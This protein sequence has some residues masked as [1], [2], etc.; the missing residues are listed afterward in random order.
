MKPDAVVFSEEN[1]R[2]QHLGFSSS[3][4]DQDVLALSV[5]IVENVAN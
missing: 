3:D 5:N 4:Y 2:N 1:F